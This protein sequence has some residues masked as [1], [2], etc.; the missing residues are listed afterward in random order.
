[1][2]GPAV[3]IFKQTIHGHSL[4]GLLAFAKRGSRAVLEIALR[5]IWSDFALLSRQNAPV[6][7]QPERAALPEI[8]HTDKIEV[9][10][11]AEGF[12]EVSET[13]WQDLKLELFR[14]GSDDSDV[15]TIAKALASGQTYTHRTPATEYEYRKV[16][17]N[18]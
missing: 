10:A 13:K 16:Q 8:H 12:A 15:R 7:V 11:I 2:T 14:A 4:D 17:P 1:M 18:G 3:D 6:Y 9:K 5:D